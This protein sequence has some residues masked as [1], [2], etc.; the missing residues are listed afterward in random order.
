ML[1]AL[2]AGLAPGTAA[3]QTFGYFGELGPE[4]W[5][6]IDSTWQ[7]CG[8]GRIQSPV[9][10][11]EGV[12]TFHRL[13]ISYG[14]TEG[15][16]F[17]NGHTIE[18][19]TEGQNTLTFKGIAYDL[20]QFHF[21]T[22]SEHRVA[23]R[24]YD[25][26][27]HLV[28]RAGDG[29]NAVVGVFLKRAKSS[30]SLARIFDNLPAIGSINVKEE[31]PEPFDPAAFLPKRQHHFRYLGSLTTPPCTEGVLWFVLTEPVTV[32]D[33]DIA[34]FAERIHFNARLVQRKLRH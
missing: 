32:S 16:I 24:G 9:D 21:H 4:F 7:T 3:S 2:L 11:K 29:S 13:P 18:V 28:H 14:P 6:E 26:E 5:A 8:A 22:G 27:L 30:R 12:K 25:M 34:Q 31:L 19:E 10:F 20:V 33:E 17:N 15:A 1:A 23:G